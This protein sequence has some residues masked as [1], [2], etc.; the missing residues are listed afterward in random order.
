MLDT[1]IVEHHHLAQEHQLILDIGE[2]LWIFMEAFLVLDRKPGQLLL[3]LEVRR[4]APPDEFVGDE[5][6]QH[7]D[8]DRTQT[9]DDRG[10]PLR[11]ELWRILRGDAEGNT[12]NKD[13]KN[14]GTAHSDVDTQEE[15]VA[16]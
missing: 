4:N 11:P 14:L 12:T 1:H 2:R 8:R 15:V 3:P 16:R 7:A 10:H 6:D 13:N 9:N 5:T